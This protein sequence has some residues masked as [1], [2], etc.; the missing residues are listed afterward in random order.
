M[1]STTKKLIGQSQENFRTERQTD[2]IRMNL[3]ATA[4]G[5]MRE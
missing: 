1:H 2:L 5:P 3:L 4:R